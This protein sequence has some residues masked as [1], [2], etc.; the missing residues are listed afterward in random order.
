MRVVRCLVGLL[1]LTVGRAQPPAALPGPVPL[2]AVVDAPFTDL[3]WQT[4]RLA[5]LGAQRATVLFFAT[6]ECPLV[7][8]YLPRIG[9][10]AKDYQERGVVVLV[11]SVGAGDSLVDAAGQAANVAPAAVFGKDFDLSLARACGVDRT[12]TAVVLDRDHRLVYR[13]RVDDQ[14]AYTGAR[15]QPSRNDLLLA[16]DDVLADRAVAVAETTVSGCLITAPAAVIDATAP[17]FA[18]DI[19]PILQRHCQECHRPGG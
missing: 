18:R 8:R 12:A 1:F 17:T 9:A 19:A 4:R 6:I 14:H 2:S 16:V 7:R 15:S 5:D 13:G 3:R 10:L 11:V